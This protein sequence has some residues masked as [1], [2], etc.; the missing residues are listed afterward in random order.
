MEEEMVVSP[1]PETLAVR[2]VEPLAGFTVRVT[3]SDGSQR[4]IDLEP[5]LFGPIFEPI[6]SDPEMF[7][8][9]FIDHGALAWPNGADLDTD[10]LYYDGPPPWAESTPDTPAR[11]SRPARAGVA[12]STRHSTTKKRRRAARRGIV[13]RNSRAHAPSR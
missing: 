3:F 1:Y 9:V 4:A 12:P 13:K 7:R 5:Y 6:R 2:A 10:T 11:P 8:R